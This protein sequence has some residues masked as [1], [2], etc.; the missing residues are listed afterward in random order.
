MPKFR[1][2]VLQQGPQR[3]AGMRYYR[4]HRVLGLLEIA[5][6]TLE[7]VLD[8]GS[9]PSA[10]PLGIWQPISQQ[11]QWPLAEQIP[12]WANH[13]RGLG[14]G[15]VPVKLGV[16]A[17]RL[18]DL[19]GTAKSRPFLLIALFAREDVKGFNTPI[20]GLGGGVYAGRRLDLHE[21]EG[22][23]VES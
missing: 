7:Y 10:F 21:T 1:L 5:G 13:I 17:V 8:L 20:L 18:V 4:R 11:I 9:P 16:L 14:G 15:V 3:L 19:E 6:R 23:I 22:W 2:T 12:P